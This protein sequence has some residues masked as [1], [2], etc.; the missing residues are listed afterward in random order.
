MSKIF[1]FFKSMKGILKFSIISK[2]NLI[3]KLIGR[4]ILVS[5]GIFCILPFNEPSQ[6]SLNWLFLS[7]IHAVNFCRIIDSQNA[8]LL[9]LSLVVMDTK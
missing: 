3:H 9:S 1:D 8:D 6:L 2:K 4:F 7:E 5:V